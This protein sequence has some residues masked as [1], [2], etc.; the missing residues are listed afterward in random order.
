MTRVFPSLKQFSFIVN[1]SFSS[2]FKKNFSNFFPKFL[3]LPI[4]LPIS[5]L[6]KH[7]IFQK[8]I[9]KYKHKD[10]QSEPV[11]GEAAT[12]VAMGEIEREIQVRSLSGE[13][14]IVS[15]SPYNSVRDLKL[16]LRQTFPPA[17]SSPYF[18]LFLKASLSLSVYV[19]V[20]IFVH[21]HICI[22]SVQNGGICCPTE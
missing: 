17:S 9:P 6:I 15:I 12:A 11:L 16:L 10:R 1:V 19:C 21:T 20:S 2:S 13:S 3:L 4:F 22:S 18:H 5:P 7:A 14:T 8:K